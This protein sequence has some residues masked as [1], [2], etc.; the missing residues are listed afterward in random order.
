MLKGI[1]MEIVK[2]T[3][4]KPLRQLHKAEEACQHCLNNVVYDAVCT[5]FVRV[6]YIDS[7]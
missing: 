3:T 4:N 5:A 2:E 1:V 6:V 7:S